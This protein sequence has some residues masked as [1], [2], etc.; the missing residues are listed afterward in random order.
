MSTTPALQKQCLT[1]LT[2]HDVA[3]INQQTSWWAVT[4]FEVGTS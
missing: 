3:Q 4:M 1:L 2:T